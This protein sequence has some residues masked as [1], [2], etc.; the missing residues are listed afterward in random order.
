VHITPEESAVHPTAWEINLGGF[1]HTVFGPLLYGQP[2]AFDI[3][4]VGASRLGTPTGTVTVAD[5]ATNLGTFPLAQGGN[6]FVEVDAL[7]ARTGMLVGDHSFTITY[8]GDNSFKSSVSAPI[9]LKVLKKTPITLISPVPG[10]VTAGAPLELLLLV[11][12]A[13]LALPAGV[14][15]PSGTVQLFDNNRAISGQIPVVFNGPQGPGAAQ[16]VFNTST[17]AAGGH[18]LS[19]HYS[20]DANYNPVTSGPFAFQAFVMVNPPAGKIPKMTVEQSPSTIKLG[21]TVNYVVTVRPATKGST[22]PTGNVSIV[23]LNGQVFAGPVTLTNGNATL[24]QSFAAAGAFPVVA[25]YSGDKNYS[26]F[27]TA[28]VD[29]MVNRGIPK[30]T[31][32]AAASAAAGVQTSLAVT[33]VGAPNNPI[34]NQNSGATPFGTVEFFDSVDGGPAKHVG[35][36]GVLTLGN[37]GNS[38]FTLPIVLPTA[39]NVIT[40]RYEGDSNWAATTS[41]AVTVTV[42]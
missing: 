17:L 14:E 28:V 32:H 3:R 22:T 15:L 35:E 20:G 36:P 13:G 11:G 18:N 38:V 26:P 16:A 8:N 24:I 10:T 19:L 7:P 29:T 2:T 31:L 23:S 27:S 12:G 34:I 9:K 33:V 21:D 39:T 6:A 1:P 40:A 4:V 42:H 30:V 37:G 5:G 25:S 41:N